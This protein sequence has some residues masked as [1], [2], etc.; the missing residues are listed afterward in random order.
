MQNWI[1]SFERE[2]LN[3]FL[4]LKFANLCTYLDKR[5]FFEHFE[6]IY[7][8]LSLSDYGKFL[9]NQL[10]IVQNSASKFQSYF[11]YF[12]SFLW[13]DKAFFV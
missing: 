6:K 5:K 3:F 4:I 10:Q 8:W 7:F 13:A 2:N 12:M 9:Q 11:S 1:W